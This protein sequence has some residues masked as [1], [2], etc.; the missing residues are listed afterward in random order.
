MGLLNK[1]FEKDPD[2]RIG[3]YDIIQDPWVT[4]D[5]ESEVE[6]DLVSLDSEDSA[7]IFGSQGKVDV[8]EINKDIVSNGRLNLHIMPIDETPLK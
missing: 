6:L 2:E 5:N 3:I 1:I 7:H 4:R 8:G